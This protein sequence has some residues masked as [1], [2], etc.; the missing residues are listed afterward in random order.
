MIRD[1]TISGEFN[2]MF[3]PTR[4]SPLKRMLSTLAFATCREK[5]ERLSWLIGS[6]TPAEIQA[7]A[8]DLSASITA[9]RTKHHTAC[10]RQLYPA[11][12]YELEQLHDDVAMLF[13]TYLRDWPILLLLIGGAW[14]VGTFL[15]HNRAAV[16]GFSVEVPSVDIVRVNF[17]GDADSLA[18]MRAEWTR[19][20]REHATASVSVHEPATAPEDL[21]AANISE[22]VAQV[23]VAQVPVA[24]PVAPAHVAEPVAPVHVAEPVAPVPVAQVPVAQVPVAQVPVAPVPVA[25][26]V[27]QVPVA[28]VPVA[29]VPVA[30]PVAAARRLYAEAVAAQPNVH[31]AQAVPAARAAQAVPAA[32][33]AQAVPAAR[34]VP[35]ADIHLEALPA[36]LTALLEHLE[37]AAATPV[38]D[39]GRAFATSVRAIRAL[40]GDRDKIA[41][42]YALGYAATGRASSADATRGAWTEV[43]K[44]AL[45]GELDAPGG[46]YFRYLLS[47]LRVNVEISVRFGHRLRTSPDKFREAA[48]ARSTD[49]NKF[50]DA[51]RIPPTRSQWVAA[52]RPAAIHI[53]F[54]AAK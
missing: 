48:T 10:V 42:A 50:G 8:A 5:V 7:A 35:A 31:A 23:P 34:A 44:A 46:K 16:I 13:A 47:W 19:V 20:A 38:S 11:V 53:N 29:Q 49:L 26:P 51:N 33:V 15:Q 40:T 12:H 6:G 24:E 32:R 43:A 4:I 41:A 14:E 37:V 30:E 18:A 27:A 28:Q 45:A 36:D 17:H 21:V 2:N 39:V 22:P 54:G 25:V 3:D 9:L 1:L 52:D